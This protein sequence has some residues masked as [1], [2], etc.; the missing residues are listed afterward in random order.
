MNDPS[1][2]IPRYLA[3]NTVHG[4]LLMIALLVVLFSL[5]EL[6]VQLD[7]VGRGT[8]KTPDAF[9]FVL[10]TIPKR[11]CDLMPM[12][13]LLGSIIALGTLAD[14]QEITAMQA[15]GVSAQRIS[16]IVLTTSIMLMLTAVIISEFIAPPLDQSARIRHFQ[17]IYGNK[18]KLTKKGFWV[19][20]N[21]IFVHVGRIFSGKQAAD[22]EVYEFDDTGLMRR[23]IYAR[24]GAVQEGKDWMLTDA[25]ET[26]FYE[27][28]VNQKILGQYLL[29]DFLS[30]SQASVL[31]LPPDSLSLSDLY[32][33]IQAL[34]Q[35]GQN[36]D[37]YYLAFWQKICLPVTTGVMVLLSLTFIFGPTRVRNARQRIFLGLMTGSLIYFMNQ[38]F[39]QLSL[40]LDLSPFLMTLSPIVVILLV[41]LRLLRRAF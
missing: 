15:A 16:L 7:Y 14:H 30:P 4:F 3:S 1:K 27:D 21:Q 13:A 9:I 33:Y 29:G 18:I 5:F 2:T 34:E 36:A 20:H 22:I 8:Y 35:R 24:Q 10:L 12:A 39:S 25:E 6:I 41:A 17:A 38:I 11:M 40:V 32:T 37:R 23:F 26:I 28:T 31:E 19:R